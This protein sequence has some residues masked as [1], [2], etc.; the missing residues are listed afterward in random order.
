MSM[1][2]TTTPTAPAPTAATA[3]PES[4][5]TLAPNEA[6]VPPPTSAPVSPAQLLTQAQLAP[7]PPRLYD[8]IVMNPP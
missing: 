1:A 3:P 8:R 4:S 7:D 5:V 6:T 2:P